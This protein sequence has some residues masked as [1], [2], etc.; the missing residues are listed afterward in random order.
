MVRHTKNFKKGGF[1]KKVLSAILAA[2]MI[3]TSFR[4]GN[5][6]APEAKFFSRKMRSQ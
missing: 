6:P 3:M 2:S 1:A 4:N 5:G